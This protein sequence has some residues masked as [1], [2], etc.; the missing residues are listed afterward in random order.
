L[1]NRQK[2]AAKPIKY[3]IFSTGGDF[4]VTCYSFRRSFR[5]S[6]HFCV[7]VSSLLPRSF[8][9]WSI[10]IEF[11]YLDLSLTDSIMQDCYS[12]FGPE[13]RL[14]SSLLRS[15]LLAL[16]LR[17]ISITKWTS[18]LK[19]N[20]LYALLSGFP[21]GTPGIGTFYDF[22]SRRWDSDSNNL[23]PHLHHHVQPEQSL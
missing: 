4:I 7:R 22:F 14:P 9:T 3:I 2:F 8:Y 20:P 18:Q 21:N 19:S 23:S 12:K 17:M 6:R 13:P 16:K 1:T 10:I 11:W 15:Y 5:L